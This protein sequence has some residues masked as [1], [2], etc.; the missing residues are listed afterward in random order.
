MQWKDGDTLKNYFNKIQ[1]EDTDRVEPEMNE[2]NTLQITGRDNG[3]YQ[4]N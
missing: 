3:R 2:R 4:Q 1:K